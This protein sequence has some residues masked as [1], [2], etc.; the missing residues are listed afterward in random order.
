MLSAERGKPYREVVL[1]ALRRSCVS[2]I[3]EGM[4][5]DRMVDSRAVA[6][7]YVVLYCKHQSEER[8]HDVRDPGSTG[9]W[10]GSQRGEER[11]QASTDFDTTA[12]TVA[13]QTMI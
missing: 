6:M 5:A 9:R 7:V 3:L 8:C 12:R 2:R 1:K 11:P 13:H 10:A 4:R